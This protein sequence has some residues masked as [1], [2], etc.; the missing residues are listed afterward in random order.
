MAKTAPPQHEGELGLEFK[1]KLSAVRFRDAVAWLSPFV[2]LAGVHL[3]YP[4]QS[5]PPDLDPATLP[6]VHNT[7]QGENGGVP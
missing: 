3:T 6:G 1:F 5:L 2:V 7:E 4:Q